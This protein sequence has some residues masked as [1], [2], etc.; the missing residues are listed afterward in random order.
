MAGI[1]VVD[2]GGLA[3]AAGGGGTGMEMLT[4][5]DSS[6]PATGGTMQTR[7]CAATA[8]AGSSAVGLLDAHPIGF[9][10]EARVLVPPLA[11]KPGSCGLERAAMMLTSGGEAGPW[12]LAGCAGVLAR[13][14]AVDCFYTA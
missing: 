1:M 7:G 9:E 6:E 10:G 5:G 13:R 12:A 3:L 2:L 4:R 8:A 11:A 14:L